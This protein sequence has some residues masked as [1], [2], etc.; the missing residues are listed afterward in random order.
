[1]GHFTRRAVR[2]FT[3]GVLFLVAFGG[4]ITSAE[5]RAKVVPDSPTANDAHRANAIEMER[6][7]PE[8]GSDGV[9]RQDGRNFTTVMTMNPDDWDEDRISIFFMWEEDDRL[10]MLYVGGRSAN[11]VGYASSSDGLEW[12]RS[13]SPVL[14]PPEGPQG[15]S[16]P[17]VMPQVK[18][19]LAYG[20]GG[21]PRT[22]GL[23]AWR[24]SA[25]GH[26]SLADELEP[27]RMVD[28]GPRQTS[29]YP[30]DVRLIDD[31]WVLISHGAVN[32]TSHIFRSESADGIRW[33]KAIEILAPAPGF[34]AGNVSEPSVYRDA[35]SGN[36]YMWYIANPSRTVPGTIIGRAM[37]RDGRKWSER[38][39]FLRP[40]DVDAEAHY[41]SK[42]FQI[43]TPSG[44]FLYFTVTD[45]DGGCR[46][47]RYN[48][49]DPHLASPSSSSENY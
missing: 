2:T 29:L 7:S 5:K 16:Y 28:Q 13:R 42:A 1:M 25:P 37:S 33:G 6:S 41:I 26:Y 46:L 10:H 45:R 36:W 32:G 48:V 34:D 47:V 31:K 38:R 18:L 17:V 27:M 40:E 14:D 24:S 49:S 9:A 11:G 8:S 3:A 21:R 22:R 43:D 23:Y 4:N 39:L 44:S 20:D 30:G 35:K 15:V 12:S 19:C